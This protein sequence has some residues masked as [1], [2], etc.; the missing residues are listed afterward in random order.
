M[1]IALNKLDALCFVVSPYVVFAIS[2]SALLRLSVTWMLTV[3]DNN[4]ISL[5]PISQFCF[6]L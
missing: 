2:L 6:F 4:V 5:L 3:C 1:Y